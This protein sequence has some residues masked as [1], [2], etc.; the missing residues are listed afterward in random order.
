MKMIKQILTALL[1]MS[2][3]SLRGNEIELKQIK[4]SFPVNEKL[5]ESEALQREELTKFILNEEVTPEKLSSVNLQKMLTLSKVL[6]EQDIKNI[7]NEAA[8]EYIRDILNKELASLVEKKAI[9]QKAVQEVEAKTELEKELI[10]IMKNCSPKSYQE[11]LFLIDLY[12]TSNNYTKTFTYNTKGKD[13]LFIT[14]TFSNDGLKILAG[15]I[16]LQKEK[17][18]SVF[19]WY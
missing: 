12:S 3:S 18:K 19:I 15:L 9:L 7:K 13:S 16:D 6:G 10:S 17:Y 11:S 1:L 5:K 14:V 8:Q 2:C 4:K